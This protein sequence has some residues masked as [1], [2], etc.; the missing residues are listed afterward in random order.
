[1]V[2]SNEDIDERV[3]NA[4]RDILTE[5]KAGE[6]SVVAE[7]TREYRVSRHRIE[8]RLKGIGPRTSRKSTNH[9]LSEVQE[10]VL[11]RYILSLNEIGQSIRY[12]YINKITNE[13]FKK[14]YIGDGPI[15]TVDRNWIVR[16]L[17]R[18]LKL[19]KTKQKSLELKRKF[20]H[21]SDVILNW[22]ERFRVF[23]KKYTI[24]N[25]DI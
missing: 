9:K 4:V 6:H 14:D 19:H 25:V 20:V 7:K 22:F 16:F 24:Q 3:A 23:Q 21:D 12:D 17:N 10:Q 13:M 11:L 5:C 2:N 18:H 15:S 1:M 8:R